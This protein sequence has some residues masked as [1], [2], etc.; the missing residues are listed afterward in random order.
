MLCVT[1]ADS[2][3]HLTRSALST[4]P[5]G[6]PHSSAHLAA[7][8]WSA[9]PFATLPSES[10]W[11]ATG[12]ASIP[13]EIRN[14]VPWPATAY[15]DIHAGD[16]GEYLARRQR[17]RHNLHMHKSHPAIG[18]PENLSSDLVEVCC[19]QYLRTGRAA[20]DQMFH[21]TTEE[22]CTI[23][24]AESANNATSNRSGRP[25]AGR[26][27]QESTG[28]VTSEGTNDRRACRQGSLPK[29]VKND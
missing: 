7:C 5:G 18:R 17:R 22:S 12:G 14:P 10:D 9:N 23:W 25:S 29:L 4:T 19:R 27:N 28:R 16:R 1:G 2:C 26:I 15:R 3:T 6:S 8:E 21:D 20:V 13:V 11:T 24:R